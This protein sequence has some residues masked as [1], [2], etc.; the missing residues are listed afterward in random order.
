MIQ[1]Y[2]T[3]LNRNSVF[4]RFDNLDWKGVANYLDGWKPGTKGY[5]TI[6]REGKSKSPE[7]L[8][9]YY[10]VILPMA[11]EIFKENGEMD[12]EV[13]VRDKKVHLPLT[14]Q[15][16]DLFLKINYGG[17]HGE[18][19]DKGDMTMAEC[20]AFMSWCI[21]WLAKWFNCHVPPADKNW[22]DN[23]GTK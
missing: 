10:G 13:E 19:K 21:A 17:W 4:E 2:F 3:K 23:D 15:S 7:E 5:L 12:I 18:Y 22:R 9:Y 8:G 20:A 6:H 1:F 11:F 14:K 16:V